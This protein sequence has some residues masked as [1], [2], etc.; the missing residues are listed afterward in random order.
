M[1]LLN[2][3]CLPS[4]SG[5][6]WKEELVLVWA[7]TRRKQKDYLLHSIR[8]INCWKVLFDWLGFWHLEP[9]LLMTSEQDSWHVWFLGRLLW[10]LWF[11]PETVAF[12]VNS[13]SS[14]TTTQLFMQW[15][16][17]SSKNGS[18]CFIVQREAWHRNCLFHDVL[19]SSPHVYWIDAVALLL[20]PLHDELHN[21]CAWWPPIN[22]VYSLSSSSL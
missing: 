20:I 12:K 22:Y 3:T 18:N 1:H 13:S 19:Y 7:H 2:R 4:A 11:H 16:L 6:L 5:D 15:S 10:L 9:L 21:N 17:E 8:T 14:P